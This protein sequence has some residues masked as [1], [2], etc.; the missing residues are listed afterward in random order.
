MKS[1]FKCIQRND[2]SYRDMSLLFYDA[3]ALS[4]KTHEKT[5]NLFVSDSLMSSAQEWGH[6]HEATYISV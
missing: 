1:I 4:V 5:L 6:T 2:M 3:D